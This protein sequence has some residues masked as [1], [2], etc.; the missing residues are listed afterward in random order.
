MVICKEKDYWEFCQFIPEECVKAAQQT[1]YFDEAYY[2]HVNDSTFANAQAA[3]LRRGNKYGLFTAYQTFGMGG[4]GAWRNPFQDPFPFDEIRFY[5]NGFDD[6]I[7]AIFAC[8]IGNRWGAIEV[9]DGEDDTAEK[10]EVEYPAAKSRKIVN[11]NQKSF[12]A[13][14]KKLGLVSWGKFGDQQ[15]AVE[16]KMMYPENYLELDV[17]VAYDAKWFGDLRNAAKHVRWENED[18]N[19][20]ITVA[21]FKDDTHVGKLKRVFD[22]LIHDSVAPVLTFDKIDVFLAHSGK[23]FIIHL[24]SSHPSDDFK[25]FVSKLREA[26]LKTGAKMELDFRLHITLGS[27]DSTKAS[28]EQLQKITE[29]IKVTPF[30]LCL[31]EARYRFRRGLTIRSWKM[32]SIKSSKGK[33]L[34]P[35]QENLI[36]KKPTMTKGTYDPQVTIVKQHNAEVFCETTSIIRTGYYTAPSGKRVDLDMKAMIDG[37]RCY[38]KDLGRVDAPRFGVGTSVLV[39]KG[40]CLKVAERLVGEGYNPAL[41]NFASA[42]HPG[43]GVETGARAQEE[44][45]CR[46]S[47]LT[48]SIYSFDANYAYRYGYELREGNGYPISQSLD[49]SAIYSPN[50]TVFRE[51]GPDYTLMETPV[52]VGVITNA[53]LNMNGHFSIRLTPDG[54]IPENGKAITLNKIR[55][56]FRI[57]LIKGHDSL[58]LGAFGCGAFKTPPCEMAQLF[59][60]VMEEEEFKDRYRLITFAILSDHNDQSGNFAAFEEVLGTHIPTTIQQNA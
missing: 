35:S 47:T 9:V 11:F 45:I 41:L 25:A 55:T 46:R 31:K 38:H 42:G 5:A 54:H 27:V 50:V 53:A 34:A 20:H 17:P 7:P 28:I 40:D 6:V 56:I 29:S 19:Y 57:G 43:G 3:L 10:Y 51:A 60:E 8:R 49:F 48:R 21:F 24:T 12:R 39:E 37:E 52:Q 14:E 22:Q 26:A 4:P 2:V 30:S 1:M 59:K 18:Y 16:R 33:S 44:T 23:E 13:L 58:V 32:V 15:Y 36:N